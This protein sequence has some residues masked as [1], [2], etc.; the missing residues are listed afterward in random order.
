[1][2]RKTL[3]AVVLSVVSSVSYAVETLDVL[4]V[5]DQNTIDNFEKLDTTLER[6]EYAIDLVSDLNETMSNSGLNRVIRFRLIDGLY[7]RY[8]HYVNGKRANIVEL[9]DQ[10]AIFA[11]RVWDTKDSVGYLF[12]LQKQ[13]NADVVIAVSVESDDNSTDHQGIVYDIPDIS[14]IGQNETS[15]E[16]MQFAPFGL[17]FISAKEETF[18]NRRLAA[19]EFGH[20][21]GLFHLPVEPIKN[22]SSIDHRTE[23]L[24]HG[25]AGYKHEVNWGVDMTTVMVNSH[26]ASWTQRENSFSRMNA[27]SCGKDDNLPCGDANSN[28]VQTIR[29][30]ASDLNKRGNWYK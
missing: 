13:H 20:T 6:D 28:A 5:F 26:N 3:Y 18:G 14:N 27:S 8:S 11:S 25:A 22:G 2:F 29:T 23:W 30:F 17:F 4:V 19:H 16:A 15:S 24:I 21:T 1:M 9:R 7:T 10:Y 12:N